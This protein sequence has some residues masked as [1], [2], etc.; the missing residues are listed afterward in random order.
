MVPCPRYHL[1]HTPYGYAADAGLCYGFMSWQSHVS[2]SGY[3]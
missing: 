3:L 2:E 1:S